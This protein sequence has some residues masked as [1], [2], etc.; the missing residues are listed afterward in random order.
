MWYS[1]CKLV[2]KFNSVSKYIYHCAT[3]IEALLV[4]L[5]FEGG[6]FLKNLA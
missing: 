5:E 4:L 6:F 1:T 2:T 3:E